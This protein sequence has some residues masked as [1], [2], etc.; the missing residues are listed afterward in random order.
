MLDYRQGPGYSSF[1]A[2]EFDRV[3]LTIKNSEIL[4]LCKW[5]SER[6]SFL[7]LI[8][9]SYAL[10]RAALCSKQVGRYTKLQHLKVV[11]LEGFANQEDEILFAECL[12]DVAVEPLIIATSDEICFR[13]DV[14]PQRPGLVLPLR[15]PIVCLDVQS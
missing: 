8:N 10:P 4:A 14:Q 7:Q 1:K 12:Q 2:S 5:T 9:N 11:K 13:L 15:F 3:L 6:N